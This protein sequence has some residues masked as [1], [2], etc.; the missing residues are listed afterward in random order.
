MYLLL[1]QNH[2]QCTCYYYKTTCNGI[3][4]PLGA[5]GV[6]GLGFNRVYVCTGILSYHSL[7]LRRFCL[8]MK[9]T[10]S[11]VVV[12]AAL[13][14]A[15]LV[16]TTIAQSCGNGDLRLRGPFS[17]RLRGRME[18]CY[19]NTWGTVCQTDFANRVLAGRVAMVACRQLGF[20]GELLQV[21]VYIIQ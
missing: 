19:N 12:L 11:S 16:S 9:V 17:T 8:A 3:G 14:L 13:H 4:R 20:S 15:V 10:L 5:A 6:K 21:V 1:I 18:V 2:T 7:M